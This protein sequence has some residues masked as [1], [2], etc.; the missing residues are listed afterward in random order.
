MN[1]AMST[2]DELRAFELATEAARKRGWPW[3]PPYGIALEEGKW[4]VCAASDPEE[5]VVIDCA[6]GEVFFSEPPLDPLRAFGIARE[7]A[8]AHDLPWRP[9][10]SPSTSGR[11]LAR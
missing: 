8:Q 5:E 10:F 1:R 11:M 3:R 6:S 4:I 2:V 7:Y 9:A